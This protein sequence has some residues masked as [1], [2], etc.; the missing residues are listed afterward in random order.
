MVMRS[1]KMIMVGCR[2]MPILEDQVQPLDEMKL[3]LMCKNGMSEC[4][5]MDGQEAQFNL[6]CRKEEP[7]RSSMGGNFQ[8]AFRSLPIV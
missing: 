4:R 8:V 2:S 5:I 1:W 7:T 6:S 3:V